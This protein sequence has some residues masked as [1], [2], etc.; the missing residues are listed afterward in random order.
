MKMHVETLSKTHESSFRDK[1]EAV[2]ALHQTPNQLSTFPERELS[3]VTRSPIQS[4]F[5]QK[6]PIAK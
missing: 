3:M 1:P 4:I 5:N 6:V 2:L